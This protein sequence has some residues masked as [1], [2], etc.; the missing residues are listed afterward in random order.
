MAPDLVLACFIPSIKQAETAAGNFVPIHEGLQRCVL[1]FSQQHKPQT[2]AL[3]VMICHPSNSKSITDQSM[4][5]NW[6]GGACG[7]PA[8]P[9]LS[10]CCQLACTAMQCQ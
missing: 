8:P 10:Y 5:L 4:G 3:D 9:L 2:P 7:P 6:A 1:V